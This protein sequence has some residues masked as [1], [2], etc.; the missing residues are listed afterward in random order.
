MAEIFFFLV[1]LLAGFLAGKNGRLLKTR[2][3]LKY[4]AVFFGLPILI[5]HSFLSGPV[6]APAVLVIVFSLIANILIAKAGNRIL[7]NENRGTL[8]LLCSFPNSG[9]LG[10][11]LC[12][13]LFGQSGLYYG[14]LYVVAAGLVHY[15]FGI[16]SALK[17]E[18]RKWI[19][20]FRDSLK[21]PV[22]WVY[23]AVLAVSFSG[24][25]PYSGALA[26][27]LELA[28]KLSLYL[29][30]FY[31]GLNLS[32]PA[33]LNAFRKEILYVAV[34]RFLI[35]PAVV[36]IPLYFLDFEGYRVLAF[37][38]MMPPALLN[39]VIA[40]YYGLNEKISANLTALL[41]AFFLAVFFLVF[42]FA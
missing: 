35:S 5:L 20:V 17:E 21:F 10:L 28:G 15:T 11:P 7:K 32:F 12:W 18:K 26:D 27:F 14:S 40:G 2:D 25:L 30:M 39:T 29:I 23:L 19:S 38:A 34:F 8:L 9:F 33:G 3:P 22:V 42:L 31:V 37:Q 6:L 13:A 41:T 16:A 24:F 4:F 36:F 1:L